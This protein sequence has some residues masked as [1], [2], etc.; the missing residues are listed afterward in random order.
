[1]NANSLIII[2]DERRAGGMLSAARALGGKVTAAVAG[3]LS[4]AETMATFG[5][6]RVLCLEPAPDVPAEAYAAQFAEAACAE[7]PR[8]ALASDAPV[9]R[10]LLGAVAAK[11]NAAIICPVRALAAGS[12]SIIVSRSIA[13]GKVLEDIE[14]TGSLAGIFDGEEVDAPPSQAVPV[15]QIA[16]GAGAAMRLVEVV[17]AEGGGGLLTAPR[18][19][20]VGVGLKAKDDLELIEGLAKAANAEVGCSLPVCEDVRW[21]PT[22]RVIGSSHNQIGPE[23]YIAVGISGQPQ[24]MAGIRDAKVVVAINNDPEA[25]IF[26]NCNYGVVGDLY[27]VVP[28]LTS[29]FK[30]LE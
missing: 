23:L 9:S 8:L 28:E 5:F 21:L 24:H 13:D 14:V 3:P 12:D 4:L 2:T 27:K 7:S 26:K 25:R 16:A 10:I 18:V 1:M 29:A 30:N 11:I 19:V 15:E 20:G 6:D 17:E 22:H